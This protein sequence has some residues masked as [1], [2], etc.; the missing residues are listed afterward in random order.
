MCDWP[1]I[2]FLILP[3]K[4][5]HPG[6]EVHW[7][8]PAIQSTSPSKKLGQVFLKNLIHLL[9]LVYQLTLLLHQR[10]DCGIIT[11]LGFHHSGPS[12]SLDFFTTHCK[13]CNPCVLTLW[14]WFNTS[15]FTWTTEPVL[16]ASSKTLT[17]I[18][19]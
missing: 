1:F 2:T 9:R 10:S 14:C 19:S 8:S 5:W 11:M 7:V 18:P 4:A 12:C 15:L 3:R 13:K 16:I 17:L 6:K